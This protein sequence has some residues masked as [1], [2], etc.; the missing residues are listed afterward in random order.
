MNALLEKIW[1]EIESWDRHHRHPTLGLYLNSP[2][3]DDAVDELN[4]MLENRLP[5]DFLYSLRRHDGTAAWTTEFFEG[6]LFNIK[7]IL[8][9]LHATRGVAQDLLDAH[10]R[11]GAEE[12]MTLSANGPVKNVF[13]SPHWIPIHMTDW[14]K[15]CL[16]FDPAEGGDVGQI[17][18]VNW[19]GNTVTVIARNYMEFLLLCADQ[20]PD[21]PEE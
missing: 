11:N 14:S 16:D 7:S 8:R 1:E 19:Q 21:E 12:S 9:T 17:I 3:S 10:T 20:L 15:T 2:A 18:S 6:S 4:A 5:D 13:W